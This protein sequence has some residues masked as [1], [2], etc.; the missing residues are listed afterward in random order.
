MTG[1]IQPVKHMQVFQNAVLCKRELHGRNSSSVN[2]SCDRQLLVLCQA[3]SIL[4]A[5]SVRR[6]R[7]RIVTKGCISA[8]VLQCIYIY[9]YI[10]IHVPCMKERQL[11]LSTRQAVVWSQQIPTLEPRPPPSSATVCAPT[12]SPRVFT[13]SL[14]SCPTQVHKEL[15]SAV[16]QI[17]GQSVIV[18]A[19]Y[20]HHCGCRFACAALQRLLF[21]GQ[22]SLERHQLR[23]ELEAIG[24]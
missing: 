16:T 7:R 4:S 20:G 21:C 6:V 19:N 2:I 24:H 17:L 1:I 9:P 5:G 23:E 12:Q 13:S 22:W 11:S 8:S 3:W 18:P 15:G 14:Q 10:Y